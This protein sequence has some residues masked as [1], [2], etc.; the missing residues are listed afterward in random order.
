MSRV[1]VVDGAGTELLTAEAATDL[2][3]RFVA[4]LRAAG[5]PERGRVL[6]C[7]RNSASLL[8]GVLGSLLGDV[9]PVIVSDKLTTRERDELTADVEPDLVVTDEML[10]GAFD[11]APATIGEVPRCRVMHFT[12]GTSGRPKGVWS[13]WLDDADARALVDEEATAWGMTPDDVYLAA[14]PMSHSAPLRFPLMTLLRG[15]SV[16]VPTGSDVDVVRALVEAG[17]VTTTFLAPVP[18]QRLLGDDEVR[19]HAMRLVA[20]AGAPCPAKVRAAAR[21]AFGDDVVREFYGATEGQFTVCT[22]EEYDAHP[23]T[24]GRARPGRALRVDHDG[25]I[26]CRVPRH[27]RFEYWRDPAKTAET[28]DGDWFTV[29][30][31]GHLDED[32]YVYLDGRR[33]DLIITGG[34]NVYPAE[35]E[36]VVL[37][38]PGVTEAC[39]FAVD[40]D[41]WGQ[42]VCLAVVGPADELTIR[43]HCEERLAPYKRPKSIYRIDDFPRT[44][45]GKVDR[46]AV[47]GYVGARD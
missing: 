8:S 40:D 24:V 23:G 47:P 46:V 29:G 34:V 1:R 9:L 21:R 18:L 43:D 27:A 37:D 31:L 3:G 4:H 28:W 15:G 19:T 30:D 33:S 26:W 38:L 17:A 6:F 5:V 39:C 45:S 41:H 22:P 20:H 25:R 42:R 44:H 7:A 16:V 12:S 14:S 32:D 2:A 11:R 10:A 35:V 13:G 36:R